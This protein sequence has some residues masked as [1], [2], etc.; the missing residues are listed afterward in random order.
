LTLQK[1]LATRTLDM[2]TLGYL[3]AALSMPLLALSEP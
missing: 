1:R 2:L 3:R